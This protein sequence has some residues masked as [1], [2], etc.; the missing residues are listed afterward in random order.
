MQLRLR[1]AA[2]TRRALGVGSA[3]VQPQETSVRVS[4]LLSRYG[5]DDAS[6]DGGGADATPDR[7][8]L[9]A[10]VRGCA[11]SNEQ[12]WRKVAGVEVVCL[13]G[14]GGRFSDP[15]ANQSSPIVL[16]DFLRP[17]K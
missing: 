17:R 11:V 2:C 15:Q 9:V 8:D 3:H 1:G 6:Q 5:Y 7:S 4:P 16:P 13:D 14:W 12:G 10:T